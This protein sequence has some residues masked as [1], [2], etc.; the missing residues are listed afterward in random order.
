MQEQIMQVMEIKSV[1]DVRKVNLELRQIQDFIK[2]EADG[3][4][5]N[6]M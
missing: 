2:K 3:E 6:L 4:W 5:F 1:S